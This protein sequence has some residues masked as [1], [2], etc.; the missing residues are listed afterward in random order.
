M[1]FRETSV[2]HYRLAGNNGVD[3]LCVTSYFLLDLSRLED[4]FSFLKWRREE[5]ETGFSSTE[6]LGGIPDTGKV[7][8]VS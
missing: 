8:G 3:I 7:I 2:F 4:P 6:T 1:N 5:N